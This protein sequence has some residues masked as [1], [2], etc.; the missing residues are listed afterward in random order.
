M[1]AYVVGLDLSITATG[2]A[3]D[4]G[5]FT[6]SPR[7]K[8]DARL[9]EIVDALDPH[10]AAVCNDLI[11]M[12]GP[13]LRSS[14]A[15]ALGMLHGALRYDLSLSTTPYLVVAPATLKKYATGKGNA[16]KPDMAVAAYKRTGVEFADDN[17]CDAA[18]LRWLGLDLLGAAAFELPA[19]HRAALDKLALPEGLS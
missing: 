4:E 18:W 3:T 13:V 7:S 8:G 19:S 2:V 6:I 9:R 15:L 1:S 14:A 16:T 17:Q 11:V 12:E 10:L 5:T